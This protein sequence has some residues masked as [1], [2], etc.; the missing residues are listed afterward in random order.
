MSQLTF[1]AS[2]GSRTQLDVAVIKSLVGG[3]VITASSPD[4]DAARAVWNAMIDR[5]PE[6]IARCVTSDDIRAAVQLAR[7]R[8]LLTSVRGGGHN[9][10][11]NAVCDGGLVIDLSRMKRINIDPQGRI[12]TV[13]P[14]LT[15]G[16]FDKACQEHG[17]ATP[18]GINAT[19]GLAGLTLGGGF[20][21]INRK[22]GLT[23]DNLLSAQVVTAE[24]QILNASADENADL[25]WGI[26]GGGGNFGVVSEFKYRL[27]PVGPEVLAGLIIHPMAD[28][29]ELLR[30]YREFCAT[31]PDEVTVWVV[32]RKAPPLPFLAEEWHGKEVLV[33]AAC[34]AGDIASGEAALMPL[35]A[36][37]K[38]IVD[39]IGV[40]P[41]VGWQGAFDPLLGAGARNYWKSHDF[42]ELAD[43]VIDAVI[44]AVGKLPSP[45]CE[46]F[47]GQMGGATSRVASDATAYRDRSVKFIMNVHGRW[48]TEAEDGAGVAWCR[49]VFDAATPYATG[50]V[51]VNFMTAE[52]SNRVPSAYGASYQRLVDLKRKYDPTNLFRMNQNIKP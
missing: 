12:A 7:S 46:I 9:I 2:D 37:G 1:T 6:V 45:H 32:M 49:A 26:R 5:R 42:A 27:H 25:F 29:P 31:A 24:G 30:H 22:Y 36:I 44:E 50:G 34:C 11:G 48:E 4:Y 18:T 19:T 43:G 47:I 51:Y 28:A 10:A 13:E 21:W 39:V 8:G 38:P 20:G 40:Q 33:F 41:F 35:R 52:E 15:L 14:G 23:I 3:E 16:E 17:L